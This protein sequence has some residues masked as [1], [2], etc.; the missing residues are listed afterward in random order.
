MSVE[1]T[2]NS[3]L[4]VKETLGTGVSLVTTPTITHDGLSTGGTFNASGTIPCTKVSSGVA[5][6]SAGAGTINLAAMP[7]V[8]GGTVDFTGLKV[9][10]VK[11]SNPSAN[12]IVVTPGAA[13][14]IDL[15]G[16]ASSITIAPGQELL[17][18]FNETGPDVAA[19]DRTLD[20]AGTLAQTLNFVFVAG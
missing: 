5:T 12:N 4:S 14:G 13:N 15:F 9:Q 10:F 20:L 2:Y 6:L 3:I 16:A 11:L 8:N 1:V 7:G 19:A 17:F 18:K